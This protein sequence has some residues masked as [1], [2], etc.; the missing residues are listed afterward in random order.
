MI[1]TIFI[2]CAA[3][4]A[5]GDVSGAEDQLE[6]LVGKEN[7]AL[8]LG[9][10][11]VSHILKGD[12][13][14]LLFP[15]LPER[16][17][18]QEAI[19]TMKPNA[20]V[21]IQKLIVLSNPGCKDAACILAM[22]NRIRAISTLKGIEYYSATRKRMRIF[23]EDAYVIDSETDTK[24]K[25]DPIVSEIPEKS[26]LLCFLS[27]SSFGQYICSIDYEKSASSISMRMRNLTQIWYL[28]IPIINPGNMQSYILLTPIDA[29]ILFYGFSCIKGDDPMGIGQSRAD[30]IYNRLI[31][32]FN[33]FQASCKN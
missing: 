8:L 2:V 6:A 24:R 4:L 7:K 1:R 25:S 29:G 5:L 33:W 11:E 27:D 19:S 26:R 13:N 16:S 20:G 31:A 12:S 21:E 10:G 15:A 18:M 23:Y 14:L 32:L 30:S 3:L 17:G 22:Y 28:F 9:K